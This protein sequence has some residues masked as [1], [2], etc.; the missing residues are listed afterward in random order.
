MGSNL[1]SDA[2]VT[3]LARDY[4]ADEHFVAS[5]IKDF[6]AAREARR[7]V[8]HE[9][10]GVLDDDMFPSAKGW[11]HR[12]VTL[13]LPKEKTTHKS[14]DDA[15]PADVS[16][17][18][19][20]LL[21]VIKEAY[22]DTIAYKYHWFP[23]QLF[24]NRATPD[25]P[26]APPERVYTEVYNSD[27]MIREHEAIQALPPTEGDPP[28]VER[29]VAPL[30]V[31]SDSTHLTNFGNASLWPVYLFFASLTKYIRVKPSALAAHHL[32]YIPTV[33]THLH[34]W[35]LSISNPLPATRICPP[36]IP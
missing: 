15:A 2:K 34:G 11:H 22:S 26:D 20:G 19:R 24:R 29:V 6:N 16:F 27:A 33:R 23:F 30:F 32:A 28:N 14:I 31:Y 10:A 4:L 5:D 7:L 13:R 36:S 18:A 1:K 12:T 25:T 35:S 9:D 3:R 8:E 21:D 17:Y